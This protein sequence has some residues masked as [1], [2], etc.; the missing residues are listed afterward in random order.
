MC[1]EMHIRVDSVEDSVYVC[2]VLIQKEKVDVDGEIKAQI[3]R[4]LLK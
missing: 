3:I 4:H 1:L 2:Q